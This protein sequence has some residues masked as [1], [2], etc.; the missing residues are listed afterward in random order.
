MVRGEGLMKEVLEGG[1]DGGRGQGHPRIGMLEEFT[2]DR[3]ESYQQ[4]KRRA[5]NREEWRV[6]VP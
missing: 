4:M 6:W 5:E 2:K 1:V 3:G